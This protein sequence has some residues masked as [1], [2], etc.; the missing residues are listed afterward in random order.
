MSVLIHSITNVN[1][2]DEGTYTCKYTTFPTGSVAATTTLRVLDQPPKNSPALVSGIVAALL[3]TAFIAASVYFIVRKR[4]QRPD[5][6]TNCS[7]SS[8]TTGATRREDEEVNY[9]DIRQFRPARGGSAI[10][11]SKTDTVYAEVKHNSQSGSQ[12]PRADHTT[13]SQTVIGSPEEAGD[14]TYAQV[15]SK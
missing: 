9:A 8:Q 7:S 11:M 3:L 13:Y 15:R 4:R 14:T 6:L 5:V 12:L 1:E 10:P 2:T